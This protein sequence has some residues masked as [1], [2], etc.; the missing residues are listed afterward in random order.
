AAGAA[1]PTSDRLL[2]DVTDRVRIDF[3]HQENRFYDFHREPLIPHLLSS[4]GPALAVGDVDGDGRDD[5]YVG[6]AK[7]QAGRLFIRR[8]SEERR[9]GKECRGGRRPKK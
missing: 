5:I 9:V 8:R 6:G 4:E 2:S 7:W 1:A 3:T